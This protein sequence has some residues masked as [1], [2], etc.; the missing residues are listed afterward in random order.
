VTR[1]YFLAAVVTPIGNGFEFVNA[2]DI[3]RL[4]SDVRELRSI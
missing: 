3:L 4:A 2:E 1:E